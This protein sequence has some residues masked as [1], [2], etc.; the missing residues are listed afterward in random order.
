MPS[1]LPRFKAALMLNISISSVKWQPSYRLFNLTCIE[2]K[3]NSILLQK[4]Q[5]HLNTGVFNNQN[6]ILKKIMKH[7]R[8]MVQAIT[9]INYPQT[10]ALNSTS[11]TTTPTVRV[12]LT[13][14]PTPLPQP[15]PPQPLQPSQQPSSFT[16]KNEVHR[17]AQ[18]LHKASLTREV[19][20]TQLPTP[21]PQPPPP[22]PLQPSQQPSSFTPKNEV[23]RS[24]Q[25]LHKA[26]LTR[27]NVSDRQYS[28]NR[29]V[30]SYL[31]KEYVE[32]G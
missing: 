22:Q 24:A 4:F 17:S 28:T 26:S 13:Q 1:P 15:P 9:P 16:P 23:H 5:K 7:D 31:K 29:N 25:A 10:A 8:E 21:L 18:A 27:E 11:S 12:S 30:E 3:R 2:G 32:L 19:S 14:L 20:L 6:E